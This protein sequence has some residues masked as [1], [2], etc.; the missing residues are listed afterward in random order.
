MEEVM[1]EN[2]L[3]EENCVIVDRVQDWKDAVHVSLERL[4]E[5]GYCT[6]E[7]EK[8]VFDSTTEFGPY[9]VLTDN[10]ALIH[11][12]NKVGVFKTQM[13]VTVLREPVQFEEDGADVQILIALCAVDANAHIDG[14]ATV[15]KLFGDD[16]KSEDVLAAKTGKE[17]FEIFRQYADQED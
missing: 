1:I 2:L 16:D 11:A 14:M 9:Y 5:Q 3:K 10:M 6:E 12:T 8:A 4:S 15:L 7:Y 17:I 13:A